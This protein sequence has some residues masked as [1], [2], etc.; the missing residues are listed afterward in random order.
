MATS[1][2]G[3]STTRSDVTNLSVITN[4]VD[5]VRNSP[6]GSQYQ[7]HV[8]DLRAKTLYTFGVT[9]SRFAH[10]LPAILMQP[11]DKAN[12]TVRHFPNS[13]PSP[14]ASASGNRKPARGQQAA[15]RRIDLSRD[16]SIGPRVETK[17]FAA[18]ATKC[19]ADVT[20]VVINT[21]RY[22]GGR[23]SV[24]DSL[25]PRCSL[26]GNKSSEQSS[27][28]FRIDHQICNSKVM[29]SSIESCREISY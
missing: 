8:D 20:E 22:F 1:V 24:E 16:N 15:A 12:D 6:E 4:P 10:E 9:V 21:G 7:A 13:P 26:L 14:P 23:I 28:L 17:A 19:L 11:A 25:D 2:G 5:S 29:V 18:E 27:Y 3:N